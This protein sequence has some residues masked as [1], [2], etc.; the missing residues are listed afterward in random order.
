M[1]AI[2]KTTR[3]TKK[4][5]DQTAVD[6][7]NMTVKQGQIYGFLGQNG[8]GK[9]TTIRMLLGLIKQT[10]G[11]IEMFGEHL[12]AKQ[13][14]ILRRVGSIVEFSGFYENLTARENLL[15]NA[16][17]MGVH[18]KNAIEEALEIV[19]LQDEP[20]KLVGKF[21]L[22]MKQRLGIARAILHHPELLILDEPTNGLDPIGIKEI[23]N[24]IKSLSEE[25]KIT[26]LVSS[27]ILSEVEQLA[28]HIGIIHQGKLLEEVS[29]AEIRRRNRKFLEFQ[30]ANDNKAAMLL[31]QHFAITDYEVHDGGIIRVYSHIGQQGKINKMLVEHQIEV[32]RIALSEDRLEDYF[33]QLIGGG[34][35]G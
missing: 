35:I 29:F 17:L 5:G 22:G 19:R 30:V 28:D 11:A 18:T 27:H 15:I 12:Y 16:R 34:K 20:A 3:L 33:I 7:L 1:N 23:R 10:H 9:T 14:E 32:T 25:R 26:I 2:I 6:N 8:A 24:L 4:Y 13:R 31:E 21:S